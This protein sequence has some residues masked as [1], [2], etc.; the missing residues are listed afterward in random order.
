MWSVEFSNSIFFESI[1]WQST[2]T[3]GGK[4]LKSKVNQG[5]VKWALSAISD[6]KRIT[7]FSPNFP[8]SSNFI[9]FIWIQISF[10]FNLSPSRIDE[11]FV[12]IN[13]RTRLSRRWDYWNSAK[14]FREETQKKKR[15]RPQM[16]EI[17]EIFIETSAPLSSIQAENCICWFT[18]FIRIIDT[19][20]CCSFEYL[21]SMKIRLFTAIIN[22]TDICSSKHT[23]LYG[24][25]NHIFSI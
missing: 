23:I 3:Q 25:L 20:W 1:F 18:L 13:S 10:H 16:Y 9:I 11:V 4:L 21:V 12:I 5:S 6:E 14:L 7:N 15:Y 24:M 8:H 22:F 19:R 17:S 2:E